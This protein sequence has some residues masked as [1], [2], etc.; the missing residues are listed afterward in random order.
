MAGLGVYADSLKK[1]GYLEESLQIHQI[2]HE[3]YPDFKYNNDHY[4]WCIYEKYFKNYRDDGTYINSELIEQC[5][6]ILQLVQQNGY[7]PIELTVFKMI[8]ILKNETRFN[9]YML[10]LLNKL[11]VEL[12]SIEPGTYKGR[13]YQSKKEGYYASKTKILYDKKEYVECLSCCEEFEQCIAKP[14]HDNDIWIGIRKALSIANLGDIPT[15]IDILTDCAIKKD[16][17]YIL[18]ELGKLYLRNNDI[19][20]TYLFLSR[21]AL[22]SGKPEMK[23]KLY[24]LF[25]D[26]LKEQKDVEYLTLHLL[27]I[28]RIRERN[29]WLITDD[30]AIQCS[31]IEF[32]G[33]V[34]EQNVLE[35]LKR[36]WLTKIRSILGAIDGK[37][38]KVNKNIGFIKSSKRSYFF[39]MSSLLN[40]S[41]V[42]TGDNVR[43]SIVDSFDRKK[44][45]KTKE[46]AY[47]EV[48]I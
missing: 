20:N 39:K 26:F 8:K 2:L 16:H 44:N 32:E 18:F 25:S 42:N 48:I 12:L 14:H 21:A 28:K 43:F 9:D 34:N 47:I 29:G 6:L 37:V 3:T 27:Y 30:L 33:I 4:A 13:E 11:N 36:F 7:S 40:Q 5:N 15:S 41:R 46:A 22:T 17:F 31:E 24:Q 19:N 23:L 38:I 10:S 35:Q 1:V 45:I